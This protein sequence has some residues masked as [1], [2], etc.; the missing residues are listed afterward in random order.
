MCCACLCVVRVCCACVLRVLC[1][2]SKA[3]KL[4]AEVFLKKCDIHKENSYL[5]LLLT[6]QSEKHRVKLV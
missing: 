3:K 5:Q 4:N 2:K 1:I 6:S